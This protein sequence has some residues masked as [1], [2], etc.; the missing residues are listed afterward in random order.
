[1]VG[2][3]WDK[4]SSCRTLQLLLVAVGMSVVGDEFG[5]YILGLHFGFA[6]KHFADVLFQKYYLLSHCVCE[7]NWGEDIMKYLGV[8]KRDLSLFFFFFWWLFWGLRLIGRLIF[9]RNVAGHVFDDFAYRFVVQGKSK[10]DHLAAKL[11]LV[12]TCCLIFLF[13]NPVGVQCIYELR[14]L[15]L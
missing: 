6:F 10:N 2:H 13:L 14:D 12:Q 4:V 11:V 8:N 15:S 3:A 7:M 1:M 5:F 9:I